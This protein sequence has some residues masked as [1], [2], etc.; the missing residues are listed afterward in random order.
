MIDAMQVA[1]R[2]TLSR[3][4]W[5]ASELVRRHPYLRVS[6]VVDDEQNPLLIVHDD[7]EGLRVQFDL[8]A[9]IRYMSGDELVTITWAEAFGEANHLAVVE[10]IENEAGLGIADPG[11]PS[12]PRSLVYR[13]IAC[14]LALSVDDR[15]TWQAVPACVR[16][17]DPDASDW[18]FFEAFPTGVAVATQYLERIAERAALGVDF[19]FHQPVWTLLRDV[20]PVALLDIDGFAHT[21]RGRIELLPFYRRNHRRLAPTVVG[22][23]GDR[24]M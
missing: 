6:R 14:A 3:A 19:V 10:R 16:Y 2:F 1:D 20:E 5:M 4:W 17:E 11:A 15:Y 12:V 24:L 9:W 18:E 13:I 22:L 21:R 23:L 7:H 8:P